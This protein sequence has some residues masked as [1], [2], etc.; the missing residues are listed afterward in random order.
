MG[1]NLAKSGKATRRSEAGQTITLVAFGMITFLAAAGLAVDMGYLR[2]ERRLM[3][4]AVDSAALAGATDEY[5]GSGG[6]AQFDATTVATANGF[7]AGP[8]TTVNVTFPTVNSL[9]PSLAAVPGTAVQVTI[10]ETFPT[11]FIQVVGSNTST[12]TTSATATVG[13][14][15]NCMVALQVGGIGMVVN[16]PISAQNCGV[17]DNGPL[18]GG[19]TINSPSIGVF[20]TNS[21][22]GGTSPIA[23]PMAQP[24]PDPL[25]YVQM[26][27]PAIG[28]CPLANQSLVLGPTSGP[29]ENGVVTLT[30]GNYCGITIGTGAM[31]TFDPGLYILQANST[32]GMPTFQITGGTATGS[33]VAFYSIPG[34][35]A[36]IFSGGAIGFAANPNG[37]STLPGGLL[38]YQD[39]GNT[40]AADLSQG[41]TIGNVTLSGILY[42]PT[43]DLTLTGSLGGFPT[44]TE[45]AV[46]V[47][48]S[49]TLNGGFTLGSDSTNTT[50]FPEGSPLE[51]VTL[52]Q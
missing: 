1:R 29:A 3:Q 26:D 33:N 27:P 39:P 50:L 25:A 34:A 6:N 12:I 47:A 28:T 31:V 20:G 43:A 42:F 14:S 22:G 38:F 30:P 15:E 5:W 2:Y 32:P 52:V 48:Q 49:I 8:N 23:A 9:N 19:G 46:V 51:S 16:G 36:T 18:S 7:T 45:D 17:V 41:G 40:A 11:F 24:A 13:S 35:G 10:S 37:V 4:S 44:I 21:F